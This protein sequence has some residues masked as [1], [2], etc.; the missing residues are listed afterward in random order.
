[1]YSSPQG[2][3]FF[4]GLSL[5]EI[6][7]L[8]DGLERRLFQGGAAVLV[9]GDR[10]RQMYVIESGVADVFVADRNGLEHH[11]NRLGVGKTL[12]EMS[13]LTGEPASATVR[14]SGPLE[15]LVIGEAEFRQMTTAA[16]RI[17]Q[18][19]GAIL[20]HKLFQADRRSMREA[21]RQIVRIRDLGAPPLLSYALACSIAWHTRGSV[22]L[23]ILSDATPSP[24]VAQLAVPAGVGERVSRGARARLLIQPPSGAFAPERLP[25]TL[26]DLTRTYERVLVESRAEVPVG[27]SW[28]DVRVADASGEIAPPETVRVT[29]RGWGGT[30]TEGVV[31]VPVLSSA[32]MDALATGSLS[33]SSSAGRALGQAA[34]T[35]TRLTVGLALGG[36]GSKGYAHVGVLQALDRYDVPVDFLAGTSIGAAVAALRA[37][38]HPSS[39]IADILDL[40]GNDLFK[41]ALSTR[42]LLSDAGLRG[43]LE[44]LGPKR[45]IEDLPVPLALVAADIGRAR[46][47]V[48]RRGLVWAAVLASISI[49]GIYPAQPMDPYMLVDGGVVNP[50]PSD[51]VA[52]MGADVVIAV[53]LRSGP[54]LTRV[55]AEAT[56]PRGSAPSVL[57]AVTRSLEILQGGIS[58]ETEGATSILIRPA[59]DDAPGWG[60]RQ[61]SRGRRYI[62]SG[63]EATL[64]ALPRIAA[65][66]PWVTP[67]PDRER[68]MREEA[69]HV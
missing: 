1:V 60:L 2:P 39:A 49:P 35:V 52:A 45:R 25:E 8:Q 22:L 58:P 28:I 36:G 14:A 10:P 50:V 47:V 32:D 40:V 6:A 29:V 57:E 31:C 20:S 54:G 55:E 19:L 11:V 23:V 48:F 13:L 69:A 65:A 7:R 24:E 66:L 42:A 43:R 12:G 27:S 62:E 61:F 17:H 63:E 37:L 9:Q 15:V 21:S 67:R 38:G 41:P 5:E 56:E 30:R 34:R 33:P 4:D 16:P 51:V 53:K 26:Q 3:S 68:P 59:F 44:A 46:E 18:N 64:A